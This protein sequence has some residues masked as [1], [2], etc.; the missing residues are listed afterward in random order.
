MGKNKREFYWVF[1]FHRGRWERELGNGKKEKEKLSAVK[2]RRKR[3]I[4]NV[5]NNTLKLWDGKTEVVNGSRKQAE[6]DLTVL[7]HSILLFSVD[8]PENSG[9][10]S[11]EQRAC[12]HERRDQTPAGG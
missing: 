2:G 10:C 6:P 8:K 5:K 9:G 7:P 1:L 11:T 12:L 3:K 4:K